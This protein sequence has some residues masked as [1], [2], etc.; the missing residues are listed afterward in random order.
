MIIHDLNKS[1]TTP[2]SLQTYLNK[3]FQLVYD[4][5][6]NSKHK[7]LL[8]LRDSFDNYIAGKQL[9]L[10]GLDTSLQINTAFLSLLLDISQRL[11]LRGN[12]RYLFNHLKNTNCK[13]EKRIEA[14]ALYLIGINDIDDC[15]NRYHLI[16]DILEQAFEEEE[17][18]VDN[19]LATF[20]DF[21]CQFI[22][23]FSEYNVEKVNLLKSKIKYSYNTN[24]FYFLQHPIIKSITAFDT[25][26]FE[27]EYSLI[28]TKFEDFLNG[29]IEIF[30]KNLASTLLIEKNTPYSKLLS[31]EKAE[32]FKIRNISQLLHDG[33]IDTSR[34]VKIIKIYNDLYTYMVLFGKMH[35]EKLLFSFKV[36]PPDFFLKGIEIIDWAC[37]QGIASM[38]YF[39]YLVKEDKNQIVKKITLIEP[40][41]FAIERAALHIYKYKQIDNVN[42]IN[43]DIDSLVTDQLSFKNSNVKLHLF[44]N[45]LDVDTFSLTNLLSL[46]S[47]SCCGVNY[48]ICVSP[49]ITDLKTSRINAFVNYFSLKYG[50]QEIHFSD[51]RKGEWVNGWSRVVRVFK[52]SL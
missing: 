21:Y 50:I 26:D 15:L 12:F 25:T 14:A 52:V 6:K 49:Y 5:V 41:K 37:G 36:L 47:N 44:S 39:D 33:S 42:T 8:I 30:D 1:S 9:L 10:T 20:I 35:Y 18:K 51:M 31:E 29:Q 24:E 48:F 34:G 13:I 16:C 23:D 28:K 3:N 32:Y 38:S 2:I 4:F 27:L 46:I 22:Y 45:I 43:L 40:S 7:D 11:G 17:D 19:V